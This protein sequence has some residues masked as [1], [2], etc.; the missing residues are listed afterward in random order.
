M[1]PDVGILTSI[2]NEFMKAFSFG[3][4]AISGDAVWLLGVLIV[5]DLILA[6]VLNL[7]DGDHMKTLIKKTLKYGVFIGIVM[8]WQK[9]AQIVFDSFQSVGLK[10]GGGGLSISLLSDPSALAEQG[11]FASAPIFGHLSQLNTLN[12]LGNLFN[13]IFTGLIGLL[14]VFCFF[15]IGIQIF[16]TYLEF[17][18]VGALAL[19]LIPFGVYKQTAFLG[20]KAIGAV[21]S[22]G[23]KLM[24]LSFIASIAIPLVK[25]WALP[26][27]PSLKD[28]LCLFLGS[29]ALTFL[30]WQAPSVASSLLS[31]SPSL[32]A[33]SAAG[34]ALAG[35]AAT[36]GVG[37]AGS[38]AAKG[39]MSGGAAATRAA[40]GG[41]GQLAGAYGAGGMGGVAQLGKTAAS[42]AAGKL[43]DT[44]RKPFQDG[45][46]KGR[47]AAL[48][49]SAWYSQRSGGWGGGGGS[50]G[51]SGSSSGASGQGSGMK[52]S[53]MMHRLNFV[54]NC[55][56]PD[57]NKGGSATP[58]L[59]GGSD[60]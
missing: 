43:A 29:C 2:F 50:G 22:F 31:G 23:I 4:S 60:T 45:K 10:A 7:S 51:S 28:A 12:V 6:I 56:P 46:A 1:G 5:I 47:D 34:F 40:A 8:H 9:I 36:V 16:V 21:I 54:R 30:S 15:I 37:M 44:V 25:T 53:D 27:N 58:N 38:A 42:N 11:I 32:G 19:I 20:E 49:S 35:G 18:I 3:L 52:A 14:I 39:A 26:P 24:V 57:S 33:G 17:Y 13:V 55:V 59:K 41:A 48:E